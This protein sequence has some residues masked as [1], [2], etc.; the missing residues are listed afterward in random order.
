VAGEKW[1]LLLR[2]HGATLGGRSHQRGTPESPTKKP[3]RSI[4]ELIEESRLMRE[5]AADLAQRMTELA[6][7]IRQAAG[8]ATR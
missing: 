8:G 2:S 3:Q 5:K 1:R 6:E 7:A 4:D